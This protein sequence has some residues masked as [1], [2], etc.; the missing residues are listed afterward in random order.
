M[1]LYH[2]GHHLNALLKYF[3]L[4]LEEFWSYNLQ[5]YMLITCSKNNAR[6][7]NPSLLGR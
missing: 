1:S 7:K 3:A 6:G 2:A 5:T 4:R